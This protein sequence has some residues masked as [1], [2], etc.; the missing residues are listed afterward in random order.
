MEVNKYIRLAPDR[1]SKSGWLWSKVP[2]TS[3]SWIIEFEFKVSGAGTAL[4]GDGFAFW[5][6]SDREKMG[7]VFGNKDEFNGLGLFFDTYSNGRH[8]VCVGMTAFGGS[9]ARYNIT[10]PY[11]NAMVGD[12]KTKYDQSTD[13]RSN[14]LGGCSADFRGKSH[15][16]SAKIKYVRGGALEVLHEEIGLLVGRMFNA[17]GL[18]V[19]L[20]IKGTNTWEPCFTAQN[21]SLPNFG[22]LGF[23]SH[24]G[25]ASDNHDII[26]IIS[27]GIVNPKNAGTNTNYGGGSQRN[28]V[29]FNAGATPSGRSSSG[30]SSWGAIGQ[31]FF[32]LIGII[33]LM[34]VG[35]GIFVV[36]QKMKEKSYKRF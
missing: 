16:T 19:S 25:D 28:N 4:Y 26:K 32:I 20:N 13:G 21:V 15:P 27:N 17:L 22:Y 24:T 29:N 1:Q 8:R 2:F 6:T 3:S 33:I 12:G 7:P 35:A 34:A 5:F 18:K 10:F 30:G 11:V 36:L 23:S 31:A 14:E 9:Y